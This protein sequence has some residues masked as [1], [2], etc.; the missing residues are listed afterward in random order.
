MVLSALLVVTAVV[1]A[2]WLLPEL[3]GWTL[4]TRISQLISLVAGAVC[5][6]VFYCKGK[7][8]DK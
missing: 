2:F 3:T 5:M 6:T 1:A 4:T 8:A 7:I